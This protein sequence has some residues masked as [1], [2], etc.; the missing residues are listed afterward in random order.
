MRQRIGTDIIAWLDKVLNSY[1]LTRSND[2][3]AQYSVNEMNKIIEP[4]YKIK[5]NSELNKSI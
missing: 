2:M 1:G 5:T 4:K 3:T